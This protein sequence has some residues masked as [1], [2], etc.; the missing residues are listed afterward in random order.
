MSS[1]RIDN[2]S[3]VNYLKINIDTN[4]TQLNCFLG[5]LGSDGCSAL[6]D[7]G[8][9]CKKGTELLSKVQP[10]VQGACSSADQAATIAAVQKTCQDAGV[11]INIPNASSA[12]PAASSAASSAASA[13][14]SAIASVKSSAA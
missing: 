10:C 5:P 9:H 2:V 11:P 12:A 7:F 3:C 4:V 8:C 14:S 1:S 13:A 6:T